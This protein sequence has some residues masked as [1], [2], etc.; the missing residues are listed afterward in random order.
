M[1]DAPERIE[2]NDS[3]TVTVT[4]WDQSNRVGITEVGFAAIIR[5]EPLGTE[6]VLTGMSSLAPRPAAQ[7]TTTASFVIRPS[8]V[9][10]ENLPARFQIRTVRPGLFDSNPGRGRGQALHVET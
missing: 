8:W 3:I 9:A 10:E 2:L 7:D 4:A 5:D 6:R 1:I